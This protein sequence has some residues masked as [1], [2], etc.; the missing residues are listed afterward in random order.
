MNK[1][2]IRAFLVG[3][4]SLLLGCSL[5]PGEVLEI[6]E[7]GAEDFEDDAEDRGGAADGDADAD[8]DADSD[9]DAD[10]DEDPPCEFECRTAYNCGE[11]NG[12]VHE[13]MDCPGEQVCCENAV[14]KMMWSCLICENDE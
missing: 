8:T 13:D 14:Y 5:P 1:Q 2:L 3:V 11:V 9:S 10:G 12:N 4:F 7:D 6:S